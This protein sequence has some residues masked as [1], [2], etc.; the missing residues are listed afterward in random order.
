[1]GLQYI[2]VSTL[3]Y[4]YRSPEKKKFFSQSS[5]GKFNYGLRCTVGFLFSFRPYKKWGDLFDRFVRCK[6]DTGLWAVPTDIGHYF[7]H[8]MPKEVYY[9]PIKGP[10]EDF[11]INLPHD[12]DTY[13]KNQYDD[14]WVIPPE[15]DREKHYSVGFCLDCA[16]EEQKKDGAQDQ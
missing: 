12:P 5:A 4:H 11:S 3:F 14:Y 13:L 2:A 7:G 8:I 6:K 15:A 9:P 10:F 16:A 1:M